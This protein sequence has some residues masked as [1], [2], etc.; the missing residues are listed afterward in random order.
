MKIKHANVW[1]IHLVKVSL[2]TTL[3]LSDKVHFPPHVTIET[4][5]ND[6]I[7]VFY[8]IFLI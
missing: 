5:L 2:V 6:C 3:L 7:Y 4:F 8:K 1:L